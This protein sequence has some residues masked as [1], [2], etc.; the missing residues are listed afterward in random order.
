MQLSKLLKKYL[1][2]TTRLQKVANY[3]EAKGHYLLNDIIIRLK[4]NINTNELVT[5]SN[6][7]K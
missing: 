7:N 2:H 6:L 3:I 5:A 4:D 1:T